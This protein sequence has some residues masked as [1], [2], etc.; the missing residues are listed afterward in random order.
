M[1]Q[2]TVNLS[3]NADRITIVI[4]FVSEKYFFQAKYTIF[5]GVAGLKKINGDLKK[6]VTKTEMSPKL[7]CH[8]NLN[9]TKTKMPQE[10]NFLL[11]PKCHHT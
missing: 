11:K 7:K 5:W 1:R 2:E 3:T 10:L 8:Q 4:N 9:V 6:N